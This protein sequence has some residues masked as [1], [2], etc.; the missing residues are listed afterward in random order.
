MALIEKK[1]NTLRSRE[2]EGIPSNHVCK[3]TLS[4]KNNIDKNITTVV[5]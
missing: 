2:K 4:W 3:K 1:Y 5:L